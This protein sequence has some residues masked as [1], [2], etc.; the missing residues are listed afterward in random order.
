MDL[1]KVITEHSSKATTLK[2]Y[3]Q[4]WSAKYLRAKIS[5]LQI[6]E[7]CLFQV[8]WRGSFLK[9]VTVYF[10]VVV[11]LNGWSLFLPFQLYDSILLSKK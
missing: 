6:L 4:L 8:S 2:A 11:P 1:S 10:L 9:C 7:V 3:R 5:S